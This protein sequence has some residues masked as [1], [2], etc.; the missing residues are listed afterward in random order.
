[1]PILV[2]FG[3]VTFFIWVAENLGTWSRAW[4]YPSQIDGWQIVGIEKFGSWYLLM[5]ISVVLVTLVHP[6]APMATAVEEPR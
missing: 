2:A 1:M 6:P 5:T 4:L 3:L